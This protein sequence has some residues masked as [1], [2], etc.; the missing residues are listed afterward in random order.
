VGIVRLINRR[1]RFLL[2]LAAA[3]VL[4]YIGINLLTYSLTYKPE[5]CLA[6]HIMKPYYDNWKASTHNKVTCVDCHPYRPSTIVFSAVRYLTGAYRL[7]LRSHVEDKECILCHRSDTISKVVTFKGTP[8][9]HLEHIK[10]TKRG[11]ELH[12]TS[13][14][15][16]LVQTRSH[17]EV[18]Q[19]VCMLCH[20]FATPAQY[21]QNCTICH[22][23][24]RKEVKIGEATFSHESFMRTGSRCIECHSQAV[25]GTGEVPEERCR[26]CHVERTIESR[27][28]TKLHMTH[29]R[30]GYI[31]CF[32]CHSP[33]EHGKETTHFSRT[34]EMSCTDCHSAPHDPTRDMYMG[35]GARGITDTPSG[36]YVSKIRCTGCHTIEKSLH[37]K[38]LAARSWESKKAACVL[39]HKPGYERMVEDWKKNMSAF[40]DALGKIVAQYGQA[41]ESRK[42]TGGLKT[43]Y[44]NI[45]YNLRFLREGRGEHNIQYAYAM[46]K[47]ILSSVEAGYKKLGLSQ[48]IAVPEQIGKPDGYCLFCHSTF[49]PENEIVVK[50]L[51]AKF[52]HGQHVD[53]GTECT[54][55]HDPK[56][57]RLGGFERGACKECHPDMKV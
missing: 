14:H 49:R 40:S 33:I 9:N 8:F 44:E 46:G 25:T 37:S 38:G 2:G 30:Q 22:S 57:H 50:S 17:M 27:D 7:P 16:S 19:N 5:A 6:C 26:E 29:I 28:I 11:K 53:M 42:A 51:K 4:G 34:I 3:V 48:K 35:I 21:N 20:F 24:R 52:P 23:G 45:E 15:Y 18:D 56:R 12:C 39:C 54:K 41:L 31:T 36:M 10:N 55:C 32:H 43:E 47:N 1:K 13:C